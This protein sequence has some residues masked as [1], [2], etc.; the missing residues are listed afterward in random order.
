MPELYWSAHV[1]INKK[2]APTE[3]KLPYE[4]KKDL[5]WLQPEVKEASFLA[6]NTVVDKMVGY[7]KVQF[8]L[9]SDLVFVIK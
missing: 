8:S 7:I 4:S 5:Q 1:G 2:A 6:L 3:Q 9:M